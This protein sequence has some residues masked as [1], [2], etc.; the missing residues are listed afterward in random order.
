MMTTSLESLSARKAELQRQ[1]DSLQAENAAT[2]NKFSSYQSDLDRVK[3]KI[4]IAGQLINIFPHLSKLNSAPL[5]KKQ[6]ND[7]ICTI[8]DQ[9]Q[10]GNLDKVKKPYRLLATDKIDEEFQT[11]KDIFSIVLVIQGMVNQALGFVSKEES[12]N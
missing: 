8:A 2:K 6:M 7:D 10:K 5:T 9:V 4:D 1:L 3:P 12:K 11:S